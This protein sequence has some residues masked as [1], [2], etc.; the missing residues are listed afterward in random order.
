VRE[1]GVVEMSAKEVN[2]IIAY[3]PMGG[4]RSTQSKKLACLILNNIISD[5]KIKDAIDAYN[6]NDIR[7]ISIVPTDS[8]DLI[9]K[10]NILVLLLI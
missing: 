3:V 1:A 2:D 8:Y 4:Q 6:L 5:Q 10:G 7:G 9:S